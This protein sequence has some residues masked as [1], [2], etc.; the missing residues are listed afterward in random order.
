MIHRPYLTSL[1]TLALAVTA[2]AQNEEADFN[3][4]QAKA[5]NAFAK[6]AFD[7]GFPRIAKVVWMQAIKLYDRDSAE[8]WTALGHVKIGASWNQDP[9][10]PYP[11]EDKGSGADGQP[12][13]REYEA[14]KKNLAAQHKSMAEK[15]AKASR[16]VDAKRH[17]EMVLR[18]VDNDEAAKKALAHV[19]L[20]SVSGDETEKTLYERS[21]TIE[22][23]VEEQSKIA[24][25]V[26]QADG[27]PCEPA[28]RAQVK[29]VTVQS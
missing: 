1:C 14:L 5:L 20:G 10:R 8:A 17:W 4:R 27:V 29:Y 9:K 6:K 3:T 13:Q 22:K 12:L 16:E 2:A 21:K 18:W 19:E 24:Y 11:T 26:K 23:A 25:E 15:Y 7:K 28:D